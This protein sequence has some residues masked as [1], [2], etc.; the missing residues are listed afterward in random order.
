MLTK[1]FS[2]FLELI[3][4]VA[5]VFVLAFII[6]Y[7]LIQPFIIEGSSM[8]PNFHDRQLILVNKIS[9]RFQQPKLGDVIVFESPQNHSVY[10]IKR[11]IGVPG[12]EVAIRDGSVFVNNQ[13]ISE[14]YLKKDQ[15]TTADGSGS[16]VLD[17]KIPANQFFVLGDNRDASSDS[18]EWGFLDR[19]LIAGK[20]LVVIYPTK[21]WYGQTSTDMN[22]FSQL[23][24]QPIYQF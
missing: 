10:Y 18:R 9:Y 23:T 6:R 20:F 13:Q 3:K 5:I 2:F 8:E 7:F 24:H 21:A 19:N 11:I 15:V 4:T 22:K 14:P 1:F 17:E 16:G 12:D